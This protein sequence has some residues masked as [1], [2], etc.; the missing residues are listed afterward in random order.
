LAKVE[1]EMERRF[2]AEQ[3]RK[4]K[5]PFPPNTEFPFYAFFA[6]II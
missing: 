4:R 5:F 2:P 3:M 1:M 6:W